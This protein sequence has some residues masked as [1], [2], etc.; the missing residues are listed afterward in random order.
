MPMH[1]RIPW[2]LSFFIS[3]KT[4]IWINGLHSATRAGRSIKQ[5]ETSWQPKGSAQPWYRPS[6][7]YAYRSKGNHWKYE[8]STMLSNGCLHG[9]IRMEGKWE[10]T[11]SRWLWLRGSLSS[12]KV[13]KVADALY[14]LLKPSNSQDS[15]PIDD[16]FVTFASSPRPTASQTAACEGKGMLTTTFW[17]NPF[18]S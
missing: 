13:Q 10:E 11:T 9:M 15:Q 18:E 1:L 12:K 5:N 4:S 17:N 2:D 6:S 16:N 3:K 7:S 8:R 14:R